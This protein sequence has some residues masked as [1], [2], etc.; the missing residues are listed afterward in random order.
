MRW[1]R[2]PRFT[3]AFGKRRRS[4]SYTT[5]NAVVGWGMSDAFELVAEAKNR[6]GRMKFTDGM[7]E[8]LIGGYLLG[9]SEALAAHA[10][11]GQTKLDNNLVETPSPPSAIGKK[12]SSSSATP[13]RANAR[14]SSTRSSSP[15]TATEPLP[16]RRSRPPPGNN[17][18]R[19]PRPSVAVQ[20]E[21]GMTRD[22][23][24]KTKRTSVKDALLSSSGLALNRPDE[25]D[26]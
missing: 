23:A 15:A 7:R 26:R 11:L 24:W 18:P 9:Q 3:Q 17:Q 5:R 22:G 10:G 19:R 2:K 4:A 12:N 13:T 21:A 14:R 1:R 20:L 6:L 16:S 25:T 8:E